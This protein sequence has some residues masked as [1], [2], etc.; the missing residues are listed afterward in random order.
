MPLLIESHQWRLLQELGSLLIDKL[1]P[2]QVRPGPLDGLSPVNANAELFE[3]ELRYAFA[4]K[5]S[6]GNL[7]DAQFKQCQKDLER[8]CI[9]LNDL[10]F[11]QPAYPVAE[12]QAYPRLRALTRFLN[13][14]DGPIDLANGPNKTVFR[15]PHEHAE[16]HRCLETV[17]ECNSALNQLM[18]PPPEEL[19]NRS[20]QNDHVWQNKRAWKKGRIRNRASAVLGNL[21]TQ[22][23]CETSH[24][25]L[26]KLIEDPNE[27]SKLPSL[28]VMLSPCP[29]LEPW[30]EARCDEHN[31]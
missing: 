8:L 3:F 1:A 30:Q 26:L 22:F 31:A 11:P 2:C 17:N 21:F 14:I 12:D 5:E 9:L 13:S 20:Q 27:D 25:V 10:A 15:L 16:L 23:Q 18:E 19:T 7:D 28:H 6:P 24:E 29:E 4:V